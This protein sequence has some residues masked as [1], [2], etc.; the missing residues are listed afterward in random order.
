M[1][2]HQYL[3]LTNF[4]LNRKRYARTHAKVFLLTGV[5]S[6]PALELRFQNLI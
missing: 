5:K 3:Y 4:I 6:I 1:S 2:N